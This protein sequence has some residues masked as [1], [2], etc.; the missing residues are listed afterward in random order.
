MLIYQ[1]Y[2]RSFNDSGKDGIGDLRGI[3]EKL[4]YIKKLGMEAVW[5]SPFVKSPQKDFGYD[6]SDYCAVDARFGNLADFKKLVKEAHALGLKIIMDQVWCHCSDQHE[7]F[8]ESRKDKKNNRSD[9]FIWA[10]A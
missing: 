6:V 3:T 8:K 4:P 5:I 9:W 10:D 1:V 2:P 7:W